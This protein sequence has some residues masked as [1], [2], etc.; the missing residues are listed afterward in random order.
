MWIW[1]IATLIAF[2][3]KGLCG[4][5][6]TLVFTSI[7]GFGANNINISP[8][9]LVLVYPTNFV[10]AWKSRKNLNPRIF[11]PVA[12]LVLLG[13][14]PGAFLLKNVNAQYIKIV[15]GV[16]VVLVSTDMLLRER[17]IILFKENKFLLSLIGIISGA[18]CG[19][20][21]VGALLAVYMG[22]ITKS[23]DEFK[24][25]LCTVFIFESTFRLVLY[26]VLGVITLETLKLS[27][28]LFPFMLLGM[29]LGIKSSQILDEKIVRKL[30]ILLLIISGA[31]LVILNI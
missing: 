25:N 11:L 17:N 6:N 22:K 4:F 7:L 19:L 2:Y 31:I 9:D 5:A 23:T 1:I 27:A 18:M 28:I 3:I 12:M 16:V 14:I 8:V 21:G 24:A 13:C 15:F 30:V 26:S 20:F 29:F 10:L